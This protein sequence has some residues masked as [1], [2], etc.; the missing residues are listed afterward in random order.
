MPKISI[1]VPTYNRAS[2][3]DE[4]IESILRQSFHDW[5]VI[6]ADS[7]SDD[8][9][10]EKLFEW[11][12]HDERVHVKTI[13]REGIYPAFNHCINEASGDY[14]YIAPSDDTMECDLLAK[15]LN[16]L[17][18]NQS[19]DIAHAPIRAF[20]VAGE[21]LS[22]FCWF[23]PFPGTFS[24]C[25]NTE[26]IRLAPLDGLLHLFG[27]SVYISL[28]QLLFRKRLFSEFGGFS[29]SYQS[30][31]DFHWLFNVTLKRNTIHVPGTWGGFRVHPAQA[32]ASAIANENDASLR[33]QRILEDVLADLEQEPSMLKTVELARRLQSII[34]AKAKMS[35]KISA[36]DSKLM[37]LTVLM[38]ETL[39][40]STEP[41]KYIATKISK[42]GFRSRTRAESLRKC[43]DKLTNRSHIQLVARAE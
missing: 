21:H 39:R 2:F 23:S 6:A 29:T 34:T 32:T 11:A 30:F 25:L 36:A 18:D 40:G 31:G 33:F 10:L 28:T 9:T 37:K 38:S 20:D 19:C 1:C 13:P 17:E 12:N 7:G 24:E 14:I 27:R 16:G 22:D 4:R 8:G 43:V 5:E 26:H 3:M 35:A 42:N 41:S 15:L